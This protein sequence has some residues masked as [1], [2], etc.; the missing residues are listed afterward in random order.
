M[1]ELVLS[2]LAATGLPWGCYSFVRSR[3]LQKWRQIV[4]SCG[5]EVEGSSSI[6]GLGGLALKARAG[7]LDV[8][9]DRRNNKENSVRLAVVIPGPPDFSSVKICRSLNRLWRREIEVGDESFDSAFYVTGPVRLVRALLDD[10]VRRLLVRANTK[11]EISVVDGE[12]RAVVGEERLHSFVPYLL[13]LGLHLA[14]P[15]DIEV[16]LARNARRDPAAGVRLENLLLLLRELPEDAKTAVLRS[17]LSDHSPLVR[18]RAAMELRG[19]G[20][21]TL[22]ELAARKGDDALRAQAISAL[23]T[24]LPFESARAILGPALR[25]RHAQTAGACLA[26]L[27]QS[28]A[29]ADVAL[30]AWVM[31]IRQDD[32][33]TLAALALGTTGNPAAEPPLLKSLQRDHRDLR[34]AAAKAL[35]QVGSAAAVLPLKEAAERSTFNLDLRKATRQSIAEIQTRLAGATPGQLSLAEAEA[36]Q[37][38]LAKNRGGQL[39]I[40][41]DP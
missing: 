20:R 3:R 39:S 21:D 28:R 27:G 5:L 37:L 4:G 35:G 18:L 26:R 25:K 19:E 1:L 17:A 7:L 15:L 13:H 36:G 23:G 10:T 41:K 40:H 29:T 38:S 16:C 31:E 9:I 12:L 33:A 22:L 32:L 34:V 2:A 24:H 14:Q 8:R 11:C 6:W 30:L